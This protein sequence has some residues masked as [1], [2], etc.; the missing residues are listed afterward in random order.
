MMHAPGMRPS[1]T[2]RPELI[3]E[4]QVASELPPAHQHQRRLGD[5]SRLVVDDGPGKLQQ[6][7]LSHD[8]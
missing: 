7:A 4:G 3:V 6:L 5:R 8:R 2:M 1:S